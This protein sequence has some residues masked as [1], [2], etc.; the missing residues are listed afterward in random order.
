[1]AID[2]CRLFLDSLEFS[3]L[4][5]NGWSTLSWAVCFCSNDSTLEWLLRQVLGEVD[6]NLQAD[7][8]MR[9]LRLLSRKGNVENLRLWLKVGPEKTLESVSSAGY[10]I[11]LEEIRNLEKDTSTLLK[12][13]ANPHHPRMIQ[14]TSRMESPTTLSM[15]CPVTFSS[16][17]SSLQKASISLKAFL[18]TKI[19][20][21]H[22]TE[23]GWTLAT[24]QRLFDW[25]FEVT[26]IGMCFSPCSDCADD[27]FR[28]FVQPLWLNSIEEIKRGQ[29]PEETGWHLSK[30]SQYDLDDLDSAS[31][32][33][34]SCDGYES[35]ALIGPEDTTVDPVPLTTA[36]NTENDESKEEQIL[37]RRPEFP[38]TKDE[39]VC[40]GCWLEFCRT[41]V[42]RNPAGAEDADSASDYSTDDDYSPFHI[43][44]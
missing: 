6:A 3:D 35:D 21:N 26:D 11:L 18:E 16:W 15:F 14:T 10:T 5:S 1:M 13:G 8:Y 2:T 32:S 40:T 17:R 4:S 37:T 44:S 36:A 19:H 43:H 22:T 7:R 34:S 29:N 25:D 41:G 31:I 28:E 9:S 39:I 24:L 20:M 23:L 33:E 30:D 38:Y 42:R 12:L 27:D